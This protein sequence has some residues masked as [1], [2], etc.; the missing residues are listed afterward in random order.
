[1]LESFEQ[2]SLELASRKAGATRGGKGS[3]SPLGELLFSSLYGR[4][5]TRGESNSSLQSYSI[6][7][8]PWKTV[9]EKRQGQP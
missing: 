4:G 2:P 8:I 3:S 1:M 5:R 7:A 9:G 6:N